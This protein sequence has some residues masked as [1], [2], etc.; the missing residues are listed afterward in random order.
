MCDFLAQ[1]VYG[2][3]QAVRITQDGAQR[4][5]IISCFRLDFQKQF[6]SISVEFNV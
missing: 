3:F 6:N 1:N 4:Y 2:F 5:K